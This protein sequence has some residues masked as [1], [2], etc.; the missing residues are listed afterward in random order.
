MTILATDY[1]IFTNS[2]LYFCE[3]SGMAYPR[4]YKLVDD[5]N[6][7][8][9]KFTKGLS[10]D[11]NI[12]DIR[13]YCEALPEDASL[14]YSKACSNVVYICWDWGN[15]NYKYLL[16]SLVNGVVYVYER[17]LSFCKSYPAFLFDR[18][19]LDIESTSKYKSMTNSLGNVM[20]ISKSVSHFFADFFPQIFA[21]YRLQ[22]QAGADNQR[23]VFPKVSN[24]Q[25]DIFKEM[26][27]NTLSSDY[28]VP[29]L[30]SARNQNN[31]A[32]FMHNMHDKIIF[33]SPPLH[34]GLVNSTHAL[35]HLNKNKIMQ[36][37]P[38]EKVY[39]SRFYHDCFRSSSEHRTANYTE[40][41]HWCKSNGIY[42]V[43]PEKYL[44]WDLY[45]ILSKANIIYC[46]MG[47]SQ[48]HALVNA[49]FLDAK[50][51]LFVP[52]IA[53]SFFVLP[54]EETQIWDWY[55]TTVMLRKIHIHK[56]EKSAEG[57]GR[58]GTECVRVSVDKLPVVL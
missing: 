28:I 3:V 50:N 2:F 13:K 17:D 34:Q 5:C 47:S 15:E 44:F 35:R 58:A 41:I 48:V 42:V 18:L 10:D 55:Y 51:S 40:I 43:F 37:C 9:F 12:L 33:S 4:R 14:Y 31:I 21:L 26:R 24:W 25:L 57:D 45:S 49:S 52:F 29:P 46:D 11:M 6:Q 20:P 23:I 27:S 39:L 56:A 1:A 36:K 19:Q 8:S 30:Q 16:C 32:N 54:Y 53:P 38:S 22:G 7:N